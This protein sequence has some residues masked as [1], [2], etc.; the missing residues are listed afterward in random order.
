VRTLTTVIRQPAEELG[1]V[2]VGLADLESDG[3]AAEVD[4]P[5]F[6]FRNVTLTGADA[7]FVCGMS[8][9][10]LSRCCHPIGVKP[11]ITP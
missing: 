11:R 4:V 9:L 10:L 5:P 3:V 8:A 1:R 6:E 7:L 2:D